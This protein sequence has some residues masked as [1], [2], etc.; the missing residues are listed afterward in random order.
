M[1]LVK[2]FLL[3]STDI[4][5][6]HEKCLGADE[7]RPLSGTCHDFWGRMGMMVVESVD[8]LWLM[9]L[10]KE[11]EEAKQWIQTGLSYDM[12]HYTSVFETIIRAV[13]GL[14]SAFALT[15]ERLFKEKVIDLADRLMKSKRQV[16]PTVHFLLHVEL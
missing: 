7:I 8:T 9:D 12:D 1:G 4:R 15:G 13:G 10:T 16:F 2:V 14:L 3:F 5:S 11:Y 6:Y